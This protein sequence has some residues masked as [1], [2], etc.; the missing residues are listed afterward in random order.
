MNK[1]IKHIGIL[2]V[3]VWML[4]GALP[5][6]AQENRPRCSPEEFKALQQDYYTRKAGLTEEEAAKF[7]PIYF[8]LQEKKFKIN[9]KINQVVQESKKQSSDA[10]DYQSLVDKIINLRME[11]D[12][13]ERAAVVRYREFLSDKKIFKVL[14]AEMG[15]HRDMLKRAQRK[16]DNNK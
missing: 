8:E 1:I 6:A 3:F 13:I 12:K 16:D 15:F 2:F 9:R 7:F 5:S 4:C 10:T 14:T 11:C